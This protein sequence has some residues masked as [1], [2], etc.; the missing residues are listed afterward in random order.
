MLKKYKGTPDI[1]LVVGNENYGVVREGESVAIPDEI[2]TS[3][4]WSPDLWE[5]V[6]PAK[7]EGK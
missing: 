6:A 7:K 2:A 3:V 4:G 5:N 1:I